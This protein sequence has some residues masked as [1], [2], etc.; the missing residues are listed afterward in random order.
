MKKTLFILC[1]CCLAILPLQASIIDT[2][3][4]QALAVG[5][6]SNLDGV[7]T[8]NIT[9][10]GTTTVPSS[11]DIS[12]PVLHIINTQERGTSNARFVIVSGD[13]RARHI[14]AYGDDE[15]DLDNIPEGLQDFIDMYKEQIEAMIENYPDEVAMFTSDGENDADSTVTVEPLI[16]TMW[17]QGRPFN[18]RCPVYDGPVHYI[19]TV[20]ST[21]CG[22]TALAMIFKYYNFA[23]SYSTIP[24]YTTESLNIH[25]DALEPI[26]FG[27]NNMLDI[28]EEGSYTDE[29]AD[30]VAWLMRYIGQSE[31]MNY[32]PGSSA[33]KVR[34]IEKTLM[35]F[36]YSYKKVNKG[37]CDDRAWAAMIQAE[38][39]AGQP[40]LYLSGQ[41]EDSNHAYIID[42]Y[43]ADGDRYH[44]NWGW[45]GNGNAH[46][47][48]N[49]FKPSN[50]SSIYSHHQMMY[51]NVHPAEKAI[52]VT[53]TP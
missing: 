8:T 35:A 26:D 37:S 6:V 50:S 51:I 40:V 43:D 44:I 34:N 30:A 38:L 25:L 28:Y 16:T 13:S 33:C 3:Q 10:N 22:S 5:F 53:R 14:L 39:L 27:W 48:L 20:C 49:A 47:A 21:G 45:S 4:S 1:L 12:R 46:C 52:T 41:S 15:L 7:S 31:K 19:D 9:I 2:L 24:E 17:G 11:F 29:Q 36:G 18:N 32:T 42:G 23:D